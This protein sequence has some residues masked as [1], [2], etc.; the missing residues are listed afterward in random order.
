[1]PP[2]MNQDLLFT[3]IPTWFTSHESL[4]RVDFDNNSSLQ[5]SVHIR[6]TW[7]AYRTD[8]FL[9]PSSREFWFHCSGY[10]IRI[11]KSSSGDLN[12][13]SRWRTTAE[14][15]TG[16]VFVAWLLMGISS[17]AG[18]I[19]A[20]LTRVFFL[21]NCLFVNRVPATLSIHSPDTSGQG[22]RKVS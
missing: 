1:M 22:R 15:D 12:T 18:E 21:P 10:S 16:W 7:E 19:T 6:I 8:S 5:P 2:F 9:E 14:E 11:C 4:K 3:K 17:N 20:L 13:Q